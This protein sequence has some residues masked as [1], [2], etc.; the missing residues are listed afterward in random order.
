MLMR[1]RHPEDIAL[2]PR[3]WSGGVQPDIEVFLPVYTFDVHEESAFS[4]TDVHLEMLGEGFELVLN[5]LVG[6]TDE[7]FRN[8]MGI[9]KDVQ[10]SHKL[11]I[12]S[13]IHLENV[14]IKNRILGLIHK[15]L[16]GKDVPV[17]IFKGRGFAHTDPTDEF[18]G[19][20]IY[21]LSN[22]DGTLTWDQRFPF[23]TRAAENKYGIF[24]PLS[25]MIFSRRSASRPIP[26][27]TLSGGRLS[28]LVHTKAGSTKW[29]D[30]L[31]VLVRDTVTVVTE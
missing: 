4:L 30:E 1:S 7:H 27:D 8:D 29:T 11:M 10:T 3:S 25:Y 2:F 16:T 23:Y 22:I 20:S 13:G 18:Y 31:R 6:L 17:G 21:L 14:L 19:A 24:N 26:D 9:P 5:Q 15:K 12:R 28:E